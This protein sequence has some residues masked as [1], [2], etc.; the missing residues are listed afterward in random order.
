MKVRGRIL[1]LLENED[2][3]STFEADATIQEIME[4]V[5][6]YCYNV[7][8]KKVPPGLISINIRDMLKVIIKLLDGLSDDNFR[9][10]FV[11]FSKY[12]EH[13]H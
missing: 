8:V 12:R 9:A 4:E 2:Y 11:E 10:F 7:L 13:S 3:G 5:H 6:Q 1:A